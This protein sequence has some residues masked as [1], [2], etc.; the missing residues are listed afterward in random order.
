MIEVDI[1]GYRTLQL[2]YLVLDHNGTLAVDGILKPEVRECLQQLSESLTIYVVTADTFGRAASQLQGVP[3]EL[4]ILPPGN[5]DVGKLEFVQQLGK[6]RTVCM[7]NGRNDRLMLEQAALGVAVIL[8]EGAAVETISSADVVC[9]G[10][11]PA[12]ELLL[13]PLRLTATLRS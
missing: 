2:E 3:C 10:I 7:G 1:P 5:Q 8:E 6:E 4:T 11:L 12:L 9:N 13:Y